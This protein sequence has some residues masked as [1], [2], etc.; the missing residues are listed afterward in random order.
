MIERNNRKMKHKKCP[1]CGGRI[2]LHR[3]TS[4]ICDSIAKAH[5]SLMDRGILK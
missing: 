1:E 3:P 2:Y 4:H 5:K